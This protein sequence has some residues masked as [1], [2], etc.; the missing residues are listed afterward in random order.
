MSTVYSLFST[1]ET[2]GLETPL[3]VA[4]NTGLRGGG[5]YMVRV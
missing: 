1:G 5:G 4:H 2:V 3:S